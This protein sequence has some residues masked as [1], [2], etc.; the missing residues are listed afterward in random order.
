MTHVL[1]HA[2]V[3]AEAMHDEICRNF[4][5]SCLLFEDAHIADHAPRAR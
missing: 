2:L 4:D 5:R 3:A 1:P